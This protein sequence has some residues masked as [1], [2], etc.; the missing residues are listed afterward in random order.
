MSASST[1]KRNQTKL[2]PGRMK[3]LRIFTAVTEPEALELPG[4]Y[5]GTKHCQIIYTEHFIE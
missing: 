2:I 1:V 5:G 4:V 3:A